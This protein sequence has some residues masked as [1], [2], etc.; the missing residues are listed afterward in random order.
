M[1]YLI[2][3]LILLIGFFFNTSSAKG[4]S[5]IF[6]SVGG[7]AMFYNGDLSDY[8]FF[9]PTGVIKPYVSADVNIWLLDRLDLSIRYLHGSITGS[10]QY[11]DNKYN[12]ARNQSFHS[13]I[14][15]VSGMIRL[16]FFSA[17]RHSVITPYVLGGFGYFWFNPKAEY[18]GKTYELQ[19]LGT[20]GQFIQEGGYPEPYNL[21]SAC[22]AGGLG[23]YFEINEQY[24]IR[25]EA[26]PQFTF[27]D[28]LD[29]TS[30][31]YPDS[32][33]LAAT[34][35]GTTAVLF[36]SRWEKGFPKKGKARGN[37]ERDDV[38]ITLGISLVYT[39][40]PWKKQHTEKPGVFNRIVK[41]KK[42]WWGT[43]P[44]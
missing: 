11:S 12:R 5:D 10:D 24:S 3:I 30:T 28:Y 20:E 37:P 26:A 29:D 14:D 33:Q 23:L 16:Q 39:P 22:L 2:K 38:F 17:K 6:F 34:P 31:N 9:P 35:N 41:K 13:S 18:Q 40:Q 27:T 8:T 7:G 32:A 1:H 19:P 15:E 21:S 25:L 44:N 36:S 42:G 4:Q 43:N